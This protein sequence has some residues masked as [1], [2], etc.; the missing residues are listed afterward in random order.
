MIKKEGLKYAEGLVPSVESYVPGNYLDKINLAKDIYN[1][2]N[3][4]KD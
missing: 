4:I 2:P 3:K 1:D